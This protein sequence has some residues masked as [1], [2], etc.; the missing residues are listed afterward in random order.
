MLIDNVHEVEVP[1]VLDRSIGLGWIALD[2]S[3]L[4]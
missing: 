3:R 4:D 2:E 1:L